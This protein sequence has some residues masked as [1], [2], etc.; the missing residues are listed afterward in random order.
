MCTYTFN[1]IKTQSPILKMEKKVF[2]LYSAHSSDAWFSAK[3]VCVK[4]FFARFVNE[5]KHN[6]LCDLLHL[7]HSYQHLKLSNN[8]KFT[9]DGD[10]KTIHTHN[11][12]IYRTRI[13]PMDLIRTKIHLLQSAS[14]TVFFDST[15]KQ[16][17]FFWG[18]VKTNRE[19]LSIT[20]WSI[21]T[22]PFQVKM[23]VEKFFMKFKIQFPK[24][25]S[26]YSNFWAYSMII[27]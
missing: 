1:A 7:D 23:C 16:V 10:A 19:L 25:T 12:K 14:L 22:F 5:M 3:K 24:K 4:I 18:F 26:I 21:T 8:R 11:R 13:Q 15:W 9:W 27:F 2:F 20:C 17:E 6:F